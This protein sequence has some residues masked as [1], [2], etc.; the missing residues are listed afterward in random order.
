MTTSLGTRRSTGPSLRGLGARARRA[1]LVGLALAAPCL[2]AACSEP[3]AEE[4]K[5]YFNE[6]AYQGFFAHY[7]FGGRTVEWWKARLDATHPKGAEANPEHYRILQ[8]RAGKLGLVVEE[9][10]GVHLVRI[11][12][13]LL[14]RLLARV[15]EQRKGAEGAE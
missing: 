1:L 8:E 13:E 9:T 15:D 11:E 12:S 7:P 14:K 4:K 6:A 10:E 2:P 5:S 3:A